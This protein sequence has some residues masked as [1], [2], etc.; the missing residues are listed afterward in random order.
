MTCR[1]AGLI[2]GCRGFRRTECGSRGLGCV[3]IC[4]VS[5]G[6]S[7]TCTKVSNCKSRCSVCG[8]RGLSGIIIRCVGRCCRSAGIESRSGTATS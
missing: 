7:L 2:C 5:S 6:C 4:G 8:S 3:E 1:M